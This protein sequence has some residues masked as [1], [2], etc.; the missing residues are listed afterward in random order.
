MKLI[1]T[2]FFIALTSTVFSQDLGIVHA[3]SNSFEYDYHISYPHLNYRY[4]I[5][6]QTHDYSGNWDF[7]NDGINDELYFIGNRGAHLYYYLQVG[8]STDKKQRKFDFITSDFPS[9]TSNDT[10]GFYK[11]INGF[12]VAK[13]GKEMKPTIIIRLDRSS[14]E[15]NKMIFSKLHVKTVNVTISFKNGITQYAFL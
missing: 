1:W 3:Q 13:M 2:G 6:S 4:I 7:D 15:A 14:Y 5:S 9:L 12:V 10:L 11:K 8:L